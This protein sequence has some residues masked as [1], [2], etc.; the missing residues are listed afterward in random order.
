M[1]IA[2][3][4]AGTILNS[5]SVYNRN[6]L[7]RIVAQGTTEPTNL[8]D[9]VEGGSENVEDEPIQLKK[10]RKQ[11]RQESYRDLLNWGAKVEEGDEDGLGGAGQEPSPKPSPNLSILSEADEELI[12]CLRS[13]EEENLPDQDLTPDVPEVQGDRADVEGDY[14]ETSI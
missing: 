12:L 9:M 5:K 6:P 7:P 10:S 2:R 14:Q 11:V 13:L 1:R 8:G 3:T 4:G